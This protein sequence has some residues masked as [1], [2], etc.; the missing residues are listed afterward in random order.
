[1]CAHVVTQAALAKEVHWLTS[2]NHP[3]LVRFCAVCL[4]RPLVVME[5]YKHGSVFAML[6]KASRQLAALELSGRQLDPAQPPPALSP[7]KTKVCLLAATAPGDVSAQPGR[8]AVVA[9]THAHALSCA[10][11]CC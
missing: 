10:R 1:V 8:W 9:G 11:T 5:F 2:L 6:Q 4:E 7:K 3:N